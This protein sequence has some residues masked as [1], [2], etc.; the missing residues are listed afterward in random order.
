MKHRANHSTSVQ[1]AIP[2]TSET[3]NARED[4]ET[5]ESLYTVGQNETGLAI[6]KNGMQM[7]Q[8]KLKA[9]LA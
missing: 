7:L 1:M 4:V 5:K 2:Q 6:I 8:K 9:K 3:S